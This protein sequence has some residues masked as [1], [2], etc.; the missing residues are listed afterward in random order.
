MIYRKRVQ[1]FRDLVCNVEIVL[2]GSVGL[3]ELA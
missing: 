3:R 1:L 2:V